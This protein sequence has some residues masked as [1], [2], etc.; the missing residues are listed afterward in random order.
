[1]AEAVGEVSP[2]LRS[3]TGSADEDDDHADEKESDARHSASFHR[4]IVLQA[5]RLFFTKPQVGILCLRMRETE[6]EREP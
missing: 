1:L 2:F 4:R 5:I 3:R 6:K